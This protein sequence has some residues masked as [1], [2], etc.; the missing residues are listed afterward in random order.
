MPVQRVEISASILAADFA[1]LGEQVREAEA[2]GVDRLHLDVMDGQFVPNLSIGPAVVASL[3]PWTQLPM[4]VHLMVSEPWRF[5]KAF[6]QAGADYLLVHVE[7]LDAPRR[8]LPIIQQLGKKAGLVLN[9]ETP[10]AAIADWLPHLDMVLVMSVHPGFSG[11]RFLPEVLPKLRQLREQIDQRA[12]PCDLAIDGGLNPQTAPKAVE[13]GA[14]VLAAASAIFRHPRGIAAGLEELRR[15]IVS[16][17][18]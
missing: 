7:I 8:C 12:L 5:L 14:N 9:P 4:E 2:A 6:A 3:R 18:A 1:R 13:A 17:S 10:A 11:Q 15:A 16:A